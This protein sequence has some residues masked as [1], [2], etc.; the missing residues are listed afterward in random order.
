M[1][2]SR[3]SLKKIKSYYFDEKSKEYSKSF[4]T[5]K[6]KKLSWFNELKRK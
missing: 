3:K 2:I 4:K 1:F 5:N 6:Q